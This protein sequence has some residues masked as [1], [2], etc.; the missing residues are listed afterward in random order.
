M[1]IYAIKNSSNILFRGYNGKTENVQISNTMGDCIHESHFM[2]NFESL[3]FSMDYLKK[4]FPNGTNIADFGCSGGEEAHSMAVLLHDSNKDKK[5]KITG[6]DIVPEV[7][8]D[9]RKGVFNIAEW[10]NLYERFLVSDYSFQYLTPEQ[11][12]AK[13]NFNKCF[14]KIPKDWEKF[15]ICD[16]RYKKKVKRYVK[17]GQDIELATRRLEYI[18]NPNSRMSNNGKYFIAKDG[19]FDNV[20]DFKVANILNIDKELANQKTGMVIFK[21]SLY[22]IFGSRGLDFYKNAD[23]N[24]A[25]ELF[26]KIN[27]VLPENGLFVLGILS[28][29]HL[30]PKDVSLDYNTIFQ[31]EEQIKVFNTSPVHK[32]LKEAGF[33]PIFYECGKTGGA[34]FKKSSIYLPSVWKKIRSL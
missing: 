3:Y 11:K 2:R 30:I 10:T 8:E 23:I 32:A 25:K 34:S 9:A 20:I 14:E 28:G 15:N 6:Y 22:H 12:L 26:T 13:E 17:P 5:Y 1:N 31:N 7:V 27:S 18:Y 16:S 24:L 4:N 33:E 21:N 29:D 19:V